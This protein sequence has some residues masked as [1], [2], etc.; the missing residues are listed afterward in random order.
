[1]VKGL[2]VQTEQCKN[3]VEELDQPAEEACMGAATI[4]A[5]ALRLG[6]ISWFVSGINVLQM[7][8]AA[9]TIALAVRI[10]VTESC[11]FAA[12]CNHS[13]AAVANCVTGVS[14][15]CASRIRFAS[16]RRSVGRM[17]R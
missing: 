17:V 16:Q 15:G 14:L 3:T 4:W 13:S 1:M 8:A 5:V 11:S 7:C 2:L 12:L 10:C 9:L 6:I